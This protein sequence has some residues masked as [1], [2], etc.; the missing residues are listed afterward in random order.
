M[1]IKNKNSHKGINGW[2]NRSCQ[3]WKS[4]SEAKPGDLLTNPLGKVGG[5]IADD[6]RGLTDINTYVE[7]TPWEG[8]SFMSLN[9]LWRFKLLINR[10]TSTKEKDGVVFNKRQALNDVHNLH[11]TNNPF[12]SARL[13]SPDMAKAITRGKNITTYKN[14]QAESEAALKVAKAEDQIKAKKA[15]AHYSQTENSIIIVSPFT[16]PYMSIILQCRPDEIQITPHSTWAA[17]TSMGRNDPFRMYTGSE[18]TLTFDINW[19][20]NDPNNRGEV[21]TKCRLLE[22]WTKADGYVSAPPVLQLI[23]GQSDL[24]KDTY[25]ILESASYK[26]THFQNLANRGGTYVNLG[27][28]PNYATQTLIFK[29]VSGFNRRWSDIVSIEE[30]QKTVGIDAE[31]MITEE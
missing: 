6:L 18:D 17:V 7:G 20:C 24:F 30:L 23:W 9:K 15:K 3:K 25:W 19:Y 16:S 27:L 8:L 28:Y 1:A 26:L 4:L 13:S 11:Q 12:S 29:K 14:P 31:V 21:V 5:I 10:A 22:S 2:Y